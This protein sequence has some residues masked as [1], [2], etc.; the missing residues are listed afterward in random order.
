MYVCICQAVTER[1]I[2]E[3]IAKGADSLDSLQSEL[4]VAVCCGSCSGDVETM[5]QRRTRNSR[6]PSA[7]AGESC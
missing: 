3:A 1:E 6:Q 5:L 4:N 2:D 7:L